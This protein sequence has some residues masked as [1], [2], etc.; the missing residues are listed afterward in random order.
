MSH[1]V[2]YPCPRRGQAPRSL[3]RSRVLSSGLGGQGGSLGRVARGHG[4]QDGT[5]ESD[6]GH[7]EADAS[8]GAI[9]ETLS[10]VWGSEATKASGWVPT[11]GRRR[12]SWSVARRLFECFRTGYGKE[13][14]SRTRRLHP[15]AVA[16]SRARGEREARRH[17]SPE[18]GRGP[19]GG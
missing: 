11:Q 6:A 13:T 15:S 18:E 17:D 14:A 4:H 2:E 10:E 1:D 3:Q 12:G 7:A 9:G 19:P 5:P 8:R 16:R